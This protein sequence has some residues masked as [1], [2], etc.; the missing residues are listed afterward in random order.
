MSLKR[1]NTINAKKILLHLSKHSDREWTPRQLKEALHLEID[2]K[3]IQEY[4][5]IMVKADLIQEGS[6]DIRYQGLTDG[7]LCLIL[8]SRF[9]EEIESF[10][11]D[12]KREFYEEIDRLKGDKRALSGSGQA[13]LRGEWG[14]GSDA[15]CAL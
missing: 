12:L 11:P 8:R 15:D 9:E 13:V 3:T 5:Q 2:D 10:Q 14:R 1:I 6:S 7:T 4:L